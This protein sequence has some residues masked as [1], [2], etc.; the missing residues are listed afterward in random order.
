M[1]FEI[2]LIAS[3]PPSSHLPAAIQP[4]MFVQDQH[5]NSS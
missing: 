1:F 3:L 2:I 5:N 4:Y